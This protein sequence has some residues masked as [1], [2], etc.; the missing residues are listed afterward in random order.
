MVYVAP[1]PEAVAGEDLSSFKDC[2][3]A[4][5]RTKNNILEMAVVKSLVTFQ[6][7]FNVL[8]DEDVTSQWDRRLN[9]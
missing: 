5:K 9:R 1:Y 6:N 4:A 8:V 2:R 7:D 3:E